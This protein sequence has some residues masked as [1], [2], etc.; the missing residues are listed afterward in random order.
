[1][2]VI[3][4]S[5]SASF[6]RHLDNALSDGTTYEV[7][8]HLDDCLQHLNK[9]DNIVL[10]HQASFDEI[11][12]FIS[13]LQKLDNPPSIGIASDIPN[14][15]DLLQ[16]TNLGIRA[17][18]NSYMADIHY[19][20]MLRTIEAGQQWLAPQLQAEL[21]NL[22]AHAVHSSD[23]AKDVLDGLTNREL[24]V[25]KAV[26][27]GLNNKQIARKFDISERTVKAHLTKCFAKLGIKSRLALATLILNLKESSPRS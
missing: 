11:D 3:I 24:E 15:R 6:E 21:L 23:S 26:A 7:T 19:L 17:Y 4:L 12:A 13:T 22:A 27:D 25:A 9:G 5:A 16:L 20:H 10:I 2:N 8:H 1:M 18:F 14:V